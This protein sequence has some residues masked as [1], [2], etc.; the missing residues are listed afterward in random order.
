MSTNEPLK[1]PRQLSSEGLQV[2]TEKERQLSW[3]GLQSAVRKSSRKSAEGLQVVLG[4]SSPE[5]VQKD[6]YEDK[7]NGQST[8]QTWN[9][10][11][12]AKWNGFRVIWIFVTVSMF[13]IGIAFGGA[14]VATVE[15]HA[16]KSGS[17][18]GSVS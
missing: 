12:H 6:G 5:L 7:V 18:S 4:P 8:R 14:I 13:V 16:K 1:K 15:A 10:F 3:E 11:L 2:V 9:R 17:T